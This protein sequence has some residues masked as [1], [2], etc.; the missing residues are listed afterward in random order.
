LRDALHHHGAAVLFEEPGYASVNVPVN[1]KLNTGGGAAFAGNL[2]V[3]GLVGMGADAATGASF[4]HEPN[5]VY[6]KMQRTSGSSP[7]GP[8]AAQSS[9]KR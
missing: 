7:S 4:D 3:G 8:S 1:T 9:L 2:I 5:P 6:A